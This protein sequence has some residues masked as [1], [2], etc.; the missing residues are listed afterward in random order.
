[1]DGAAQLAS[2]F[3]FSDEFF[4]T[5]PKATT[6]P[7][8]GVRTRKV[9]FPMSK[10]QHQWRPRWNHVWGWIG[11]GRKGHLVGV[12]GNLNRHQYIGWSSHSIGR[13]NLRPSKSPLCFPAG[14][15]STPHCSCYNPHCW[16]DKTFRSCH[17]HRIAPIRTLWSLCGITLF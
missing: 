14:Q 11:Y 17:C 12:D 13:G 16:R 3:F 8:C 1:M 10:E 15:C 6:E 7:S 5:L 2:R 4:V 9:C